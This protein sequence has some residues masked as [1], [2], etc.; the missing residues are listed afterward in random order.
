VARLGVGELA[1]NQ[2]GDTAYVNDQ[3][4]LRMIQHLDAGL[5]HGV[6]VVPCDSLLSA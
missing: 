3:T 4:W 2:L 1:M 5:R 6:S